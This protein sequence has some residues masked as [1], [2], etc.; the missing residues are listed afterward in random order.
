MQC[1]S[2]S[3]LMPIPQFPTQLCINSPDATS[4]AW[5]ELAKS[6]PLCVTQF[7]PTILP[8]F[9]HRT[10]LGFFVF[11]FSEPSKE[12]EQIIL[13]FLL[14]SL[15]FIH[16]LSMIFKIAIINHLFKGWLVSFSNFSIVEGL[17]G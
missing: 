13:M 17:R 11:L 12:K 6:L 10:S 8:P 7:K 3:H 5:H 16:I 15:Y 14:K 1:K 2:S 4:M 9:Y